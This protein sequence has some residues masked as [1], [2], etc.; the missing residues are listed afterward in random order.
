MRT[1]RFCLS[2]YL[3]I[4]LLN[5]N[6]SAFAVTVVSST[7]EHKIVGLDPGI[8][9]YLKQRIPVGATGCG[10][11]V[12]LFL[13]PFSVLTAQAFD[14]P[15]FSWMEYLA[16]RGVGS[17]ALDFRGFGQSSRPPEMNQPP[18]AH[19]PV[20]RAA[21]AGIRD[22]SAAVTFIQTHC[23]I[24]SLNLVGWSWGGV[25]AGM[26]ASTNPSAVQRLV[27]LGT[28]HA[29]DLP[30]MTRMFDAPDAPGTL[31]PHLPAYQIVPVEAMLG[32]WNMMLSMIKESQRAD[33]RS[34][35]ALA[36]VSA[37]FLASDPAPPQPE[38]VRRP[39]GPLVDLYAIWSSRPLYAAAQIKV[40][41]LIV[42]G[43][44]D[45]FADPGLIAH[46]TGACMRHEV[47][48]KNATHWLLYE[49]HREQLLTAVD[50]FL[51]QEI[52][53]H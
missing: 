30:A 37:V 46:L 24:S 17:F 31:N 48:V 9:L 15:G 49:Q 21:D 11:Q 29:F 38:R 35:A 51:N 7:L 26:Y 10:K 44:H 41:T 4:V 12:V 1:V 53:C 19:G 5:F 45:G 8:S 33:I 36:A 16:Q 3:A 39:L 22:L 2:V 52:D 23:G 43:D 27:L 32:H 13:H 50:D 20:V 42:R 18:A 6:A 47:V 25:V 14:V 34:P 28:M 40:P